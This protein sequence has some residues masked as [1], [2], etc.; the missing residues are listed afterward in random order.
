MLCFIT[1]L[2][3]LKRRNTIIRLN[4][5]IQT[6]VG[7]D[8]SRTS[9]IYRPS[10]AFHTIPFSLF[11]AIIVPSINTTSILS[12]ADRLDPVCERNVLNTHQIRRKLS[13]RAR[14]PFVTFSVTLMRRS[15][16]NISVRKAAPACTG[17]SY[18]VSD[19]EQ[20]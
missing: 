9:P 20:L 8:L 10:V 18:R 19:Q 16:G 15:Y 1:P 4:E 3:Q 2:F 17:S 7:A 13:I 14:L 11:K 5:I 12:N 6:P